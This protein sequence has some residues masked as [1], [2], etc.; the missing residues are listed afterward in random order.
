[1]EQR[2]TNVR[3]FSRRRTEPVEDLLLPDFYSGASG[4]PGCFT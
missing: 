4:L 1:M 3:G 2:E